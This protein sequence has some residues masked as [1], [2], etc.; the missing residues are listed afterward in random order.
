M[1]KCS[2]SDLDSLRDFGLVHGLTGTDMEIQIGGTLNLKCEYPNERFNRDIFDAW[3]GDFTLTLLCRPD[4]AF[5]V[6][7]GIFRNGMCT[8]W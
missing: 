5:D 1:A 4:K 7:D 8:A 6:P 2:A 3:P